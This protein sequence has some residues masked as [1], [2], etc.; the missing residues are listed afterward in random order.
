[1]KFFMILMLLPGFIH[2]KAYKCE[3]NGKTAYQ[4]SPCPDDGHELKI[5]NPPSNTG[6]PNQYRIRMG[7]VGVGMTKDDVV[8]SW[9]RPQKIN[10]SSRSEQWI[11]IHKYRKPYEGY[12]GRIRYY[13]AEK[14]QYIHF[15]NAG[16]VTSWSN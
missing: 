13:D 8:L 5:D 14:R 6:N 16:V 9:G 2:A 3:V 11:Y 12:K 4:Q 15:N 1:M 7:K 10:R